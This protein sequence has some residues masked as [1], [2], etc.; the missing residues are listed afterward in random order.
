MWQWWSCF[1]LQQLFIFGCCCL[2]T[3]V[4]SFK[5]CSEPVVNFFFF[6]YKTNFKL[7][8]LHH[9]V[10][11]KFSFFFLKLDASQYFF[12][13]FVFYFDFNWKV[14]IWKLSITAFFDE[15]GYTL[16][17]PPIYYNYNIVNDNCNRTVSHNCAAPFFCGKHLYYFFLNIIFLQF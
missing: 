3:S 4:F 15:Q 12:W 2:C 16:I 11:L 14:D 8:V 7:N 17:I 10:V 6:F 13:F 1:Q 5:T 9:Q